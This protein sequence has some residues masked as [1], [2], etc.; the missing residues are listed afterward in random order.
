[1]SLAQHLVELRRRLIIS[2]L[3]IVVGLVAGF[4]VADVVIDALRGPLTL[5]AET[6]GRNAGITFGGVTTGFDLRM[7]I[8]VT[9][10]IVVASP[11]WLYQIWA[12]LVPG[13]VRREK[14]YAIGFLGAAI[15]LFLAGCYAGWWVFPHIV[16]LMLGFVG[17]EDNILL[18]AKEYYD[19][20]LKLMLA[21]GVA[22]VLPVF[23][24]LLNFAGVLSASSIIKSWRIAILVITLFT[25]TA[26]PAA[27]V[28]SMFLLAVP[29]IL[30]YFAAYGVAYLH[31]RRAKK[32]ADALDAE[33]AT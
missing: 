14:L 7:Q 23:L 28:M 5:V 16:E 11:V 15:P 12:F 27:D 19:F 21:V 9:I 32:R 30:L 3:A 25:A 33:L 1:M 17:L 29:M 6:S 26:T 22:F 31:D 8:A 2:A 18:T 13:L 20:V 24:V 4:V 10:G